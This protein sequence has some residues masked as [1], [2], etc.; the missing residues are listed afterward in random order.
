MCFIAN[1]SIAACFSCANPNFPLFFYDPFL[2]SKQ[3]SF[4]TDFLAALS[5]PCWGDRFVMPLL[6]VA[7]IVSNSFLLLLVRH[8]LLEAMH[9]LLVA[10][11]VSYCFLYTKSLRRKRS[12]LD[13]SHDR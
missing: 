5:T 1:N 10:D 11:I 9:L 6:V 12:Q 3:H 2:A 8:L 4:G 13:R 7:N